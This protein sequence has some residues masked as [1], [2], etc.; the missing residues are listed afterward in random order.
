MAAAIRSF[1]AMTHPHKVMILGAM[2]ELGE[3]SDAEHSNIL[4]LAISMKESRVICVG[5]AFRKLASAA[6]LEWFADAHLLGAAL[7]DEQLE[8]ALILV[9]G[10]RAMQLEGVLAA[11]E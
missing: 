7:K 11:F 2:M 3:Y 6:G 9:K 5:D 8:D 10:S 1:G 4:G